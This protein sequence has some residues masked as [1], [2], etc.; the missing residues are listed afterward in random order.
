MSQT[1]T[2]TPPEINVLDESGHP[3][4]HMGAPE[5]GLLD[6][7]GRAIPRRRAAQGALAQVDAAVRAYPWFALA[8]GVIAGYGIAPR[9]RR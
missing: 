5:P 9:R 1:T 8:I 4:N 3:V 6:H 2:P 7:T